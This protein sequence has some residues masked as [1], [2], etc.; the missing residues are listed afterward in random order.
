VRVTAAV[1]DAAGTGG[2]VVPYNK[3]HAQQAQCKKRGVGKGKTKKRRDS[4]SD[5]GDSG[6]GGKGGKKRKRGHKGANK[7]KRV[8][9]PGRDSSS[10]SKPSSSSGSD[11]NDTSDESTSGQFTDD[12]ANSSELED[13]ANGGSGSKA[14]KRE[15]ERRQMDWELLKIAWPI[16]DRPL[17]LRKKKNVM[18]RSMDEL[19]RLKKEVAGEEERR[20]LG[21][22]AFT[23]DAIVKK[24]KYKAATDDGYTKLHPARSARQPLARPSKWFGKHVPA[25]RTVIVRNFPLEHYGAANQVTL[26]L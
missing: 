16:E 8:R 6:D 10:S 3:E 22:S 7:K 13:T 14:R 15:R 20:E 9:R 24:T 19:L 18:G 11:S 4:S 21:E 25:R 5:S 12:G 23:R 17:F 1:T 26:A 2:E